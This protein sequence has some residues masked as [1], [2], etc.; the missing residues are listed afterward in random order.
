MST[1]R[2]SDLEAGLNALRDDLN[3]SRI[4]IE[5]CRGLVRSLHERLDGVEAKQELV[6][7]GKKTQRG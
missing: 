7:P 2:I 5:E 1:R 4:A 6:R 3:E